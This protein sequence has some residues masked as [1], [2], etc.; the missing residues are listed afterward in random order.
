AEEFAR[1]EQLLWRTH[2]T[3][4]DDD[5]S[6]AYW[7]LWQLYQQR[8]RRSAPW[9][10]RSGA[11]QLSP[12]GGRLAVVR[13]SEVEIYDVATGRMQCALPFAPAYLSPAFSRDGSRLG[14]FLRAGSVTVW[15]LDPAPT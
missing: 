10:R 11:P 1:A 5:D 7:R 8:P 2:F 9:I 4:P 6:R 3:R 12:D 13:I 14:A 15:D